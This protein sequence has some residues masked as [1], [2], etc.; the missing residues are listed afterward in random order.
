MGACHGENLYSVSCGLASP[1]AWADHD[2][3]GSLA[4]TTAA[5]LTIS[6]NFFMGKPLT[7]LLAGFALN[8]HGSFVKGLTP[9][10]AGVAGLLLSFRLRQPPILKD[11]C[12]LSSPAATASRPS[13]A[14][15]TSFPFNPAVSAT[16]AYPPETVKAP[17][18]FAL[19][20]MAF[21]AF[22]AFIA[23][24]AFMADMA[25]IGKTIFQKVHGNPY[26]ATNREQ[27]R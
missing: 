1:P 15:L 10:R 7:V 11:P 13:T 19:A 14:A 26:K 2:S 20:F 3:C 17:D 18:V 22:M 23:F 9:F 6:L 16:A 8:T 24:I 25:F 21:M 4:L 27:E 12:F 5:Q